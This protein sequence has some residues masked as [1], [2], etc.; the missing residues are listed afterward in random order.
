[1]RIIQLMPTI[2]FG[3]AVGNDARAIGDILR[4]LGCETQI[5]AENID[6]RLPEGT[7][8]P[9]RELPPLAEEDVV[10]YHGSTGTEL[11]FRLPE[12]GGR[13]VMIYHN[14][15]PPEYFAPYSQAAAALTQSGL[16]GIR[17][18][19]DKLTYCIA[20]SDYNREDLLR[21]GYTCPIDVCPVIVPFSDYEK[22][23]DPSVIAH[24]RGDGVTNL[25]FVGR[26]APNKKQEDVIAA[27][28]HYHKHYNP[29]S[30]LFLVG[31]WSGM[32]A[33]HRQLLRYIEKLGLSDAVIFPGHIRFEEILAYY[34]LADVFVC[35]SEHEG[36][37]VPLVE[38]MHFGV[39]IV[40]RRAAAVPY[41]MGGKGLLLD[42]ADPVYAA[43]VIH[44][45]VTDK[46]LREYVIRLQKRRLED[47]SY[48]HVRDTFTAC[49][50]GFLWRVPA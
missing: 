45:A 22:E 47:F 46:A 44:R 27:F 39:P 29:S 23:P 5:Y 37:C 8:L 48:E 33:Y 12:L 13:K 38:A 7:A 11:N 3:D 18:L 17:Y 6:T 15:T 24:Y 25:L 16:D 50:N 9:V 30:R 10:L 42:D 19:A 21:M 34:T 41:T 28:Y 2:S 32:D 43:A 1:M 35:M 26:I 14:I 31:S 20:D 49:I 36:F 4:E 40:A